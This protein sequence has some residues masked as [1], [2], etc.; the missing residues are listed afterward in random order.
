MRRV[1]PQRSITNGLGAGRARACRLLLPN[2]APRSPGSPHRH[3]IPTRTT[4]T[5]EPVLA[6]SGLVGSHPDPSK[7][8][9]LCQLPLCLASQPTWRSK[10]ATV[11]HILAWKPLNPS[12]KAA[13]GREIKVSTALESSSRHRIPETSNHPCP[14]LH[15]H[16]LYEGTAP[17]WHQLYHQPPRHYQNCLIKKKNT[18]KPVTPPKEQV[19]PCRAPTNSMHRFIP[20][21]PPGLPRGPPLAAGA[22]LTR[23]CA[24]DWLPLVR[25]ALPQTPSPAT[26][27]ALRP[28]ALSQYIKTRR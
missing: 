2:P 25:A 24:G 23:R 7:I 10:K 13:P 5:A 21:T 14:C 4:P 26:G 3:S 9:C 27:G 11:R 8:L 16:P 17:S 22:S 20:A 15:R 6:T 12:Q 1:I 18:L 19:P 28:R